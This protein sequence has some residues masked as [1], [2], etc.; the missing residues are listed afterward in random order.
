MAPAIICISM[1]ELGHKNG[2]HQCQ[3]PGG[4]QLPPASPGGTPSLVSQS[5]LPMDY[6]LFYLVFLF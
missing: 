4:T 5:L 6:A 1:A 2:G 3:S